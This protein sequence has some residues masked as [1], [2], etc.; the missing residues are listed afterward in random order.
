MSIFFRSFEQTG[1]NQFSGQQTDFNG[2]VALDSLP[3]NTIAVITLY[4]YSVDGTANDCTLALAPTSTGDPEDS[5]ILEELTG[6][7]SFTSACEVPV[8]KDT[9]TGDSFVLLFTTTNKDDNGILR[10]VYEIRSF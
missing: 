9:G 7:N 2:F 3:L 10:V 5:I 4:S 6:I 1:S 8:P